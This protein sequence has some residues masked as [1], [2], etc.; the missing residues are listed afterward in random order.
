MAT[1]PWMKK[2]WDAKAM[3]ES[4]GVLRPLVT[5]SKLKDLFESC[6]N[7]SAGFH[8]KGIKDVIKAYLIS[9]V[10]SLIWF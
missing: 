7:R 10:I 1:R 6:A 9:L 3:K 8:E 4:T 2:G 5:L